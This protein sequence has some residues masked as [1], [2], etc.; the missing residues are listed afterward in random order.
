M[1][2]KKLNR[3]DY[4][5]SCEHILSERGYVFVQEKPIQGFP[6]SD[7]AIYCKNCGQKINPELESVASDVNIFLTALS[8]PKIK[9]IAFVAPSV[10][11]G[12]GEVFDV[13]KDCQHK[14]VTA[15]KKLGVHAVF[16]MN[17][18][19]DLTIME[20]SKEFAE[21][22]ASHKNL[23]LLTSCCPAWVNYLEKMQP[24]LLQY[25][26]SC[27]SPQQMMGAIINSYYA[28]QEKV[29]STELFVVS[30]VPC[31]AKK[32]ERIKSGVNTRVGYD[33][34]AA[35]TTKELAGI[36]KNNKIDFAGLEDS[37]FDRLFKNYSGSGSGF[38]ISGGVSEAVVNN[39]FENITY[40]TTKKDGYTQ[41]IAH[42]DKGN[43]YI[44]QVQGVTNANKLFEQIKAHKCKYHLVEVMA[45]EGGCIGG[46]GQ[47]SHNNLVW[48]KNVLKTARKNNKTQRAK[49]NPII[50]KLYKDYLTPQKACDLLHVKK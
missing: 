50:K 16:S 18:G 31:L 44:A 24:D 14:I 15:L 17:F 43:I 41:K 26:S 28:E 3:K 10:R 49:D 5:L 9:V 20:E 40:T 34:D 13:K 22:L 7:N 47:P 25:L 27:K 6:V 32:L 21:R 36:I 12:I 4:C 48:R 46:P 38:G 23:P 45:C 35:I 19:A 30:I 39:L 33:V 11:A 8:N 1:F 42:T 37:D 29:L 2:M